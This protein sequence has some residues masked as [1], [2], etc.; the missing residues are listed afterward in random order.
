MKKPAGHNYDKTHARRQAK[1]MA[2]FTQ[3][4]DALRLAEDAR[5]HA[6]LTPVA[7]SGEP[8]VIEHGNPRESVEARRTPNPV[9]R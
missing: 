4:R 5:T 8:H 3:M 2:L 6:P 1:R 7:D 9:E